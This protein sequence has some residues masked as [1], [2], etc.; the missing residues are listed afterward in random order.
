MAVSRWCAVLLV[1]CLPASLA[2]PRAAAPLASDVP[3][4]LSAMWN[5]EHGLVRDTNGDAVADAVAA[6]IV[7]PDAP[8]VRE[9]QAATNLAA[10]LAFETT[11]LTMPI[12]V[13]QGSALPAGTLPILLG[14]G[15]ALVTRLA[16]SGAIDLKTLQKGQGLIAVVPRAPGEG[17]ALVV[18][19]QDDEGTLAAASLVAGRLPR[20]WN[21]SGITLSG[22]EDGVARYLRSR[23]VEAGP[24]VLTSIVGAL[25]SA[26]RI[27][28]PFSSA[29]SCSS[30]S[31]SSRGPAE[32]V[33]KRTRN[34]RLKA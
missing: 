4:P 21:M 13:R 1:C 17:A 6:R 2:G 27:R 30:P 33:L 12:V 10:R 9:I 31:A 22:I 16:S 3:P 15:N 26:T 28:C 14:G 32:R 20:L 8:T 34:S 5:L 19:G 25:T 23:S 24:P 18:A 7:V 29:R 11:A